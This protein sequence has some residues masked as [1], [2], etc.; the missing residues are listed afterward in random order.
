MARLNPEVSRRL[1]LHSSPKETGSLALN[2]FDDARYEVVFTDSRKV[3]EGRQLWRGMVVNHPDS[4]VLMSFAD[5]ALAGTIVFPGQKAFQIQ[6]TASGSQRISE[7]NGR[8][9]PAC[10]AAR[11]GE[12]CSHIQHVMEP[13][14]A[15]LPKSGGGTN[16]IID[17]LVVYTSGARSGAGG[18]TGMQAMVDVAMAEANVALE[19]S[20]VPA[21]FQLVHCAEIDY[22]DTEDLHEVLDR[23]EED[24]EESPGEDQGPIRGVH[25]L[26]RQYR[27]DLV[28]MVVE[29]VGGPAGM[30]NLMRDVEVE[31]SRKAF[32]VVRR[33]FLNSYFLLAHELAH[34]LGCQH[35]RENSSGP[36]AFTFAH[37]HRFEV[38]GTNYHTVLAYQPGLA[39]PYFSNPEV[40]FLGVPT[41][42]VEGVSNAANNAWTI[43]LAASTVAQFSSLLPTGIPPQVSLVAPVNGAVFPAPAVV[44]LT[45]AASDVD[46]QI[47]KVEFHINGSEWATVHA[48]PF[49]IF[50]SN[51][52]AG[53]FSLRAKAYDT[54]GLEARSAL[55]S[56][57]FTNPPPK[58]D[59][60]AS[61]RQLDGSFQ[62]RLLGASGQG[63]RIEATSDLNEWSLL[64]N[65]TF[66]TEEY[67]FVDFGATNQP[68]RFYRVVPDL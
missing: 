28:C 37:G 63:F 7:V 6:T 31:F 48:P 4:L 27:A 40:T 19:N 22:S 46:G 57:I 61:H 14:G 2:L 59:L 34:N 25:D 10:A 16:E 23:L 26:R 15:N 5:G 50:W 65:D 60:T 67:D 44:E 41:G 51:G 49:R 43:Q 18:V 38:G 9:G 36:G 35:D 42:V 20:L 21:R 55:V 3:G 39:I 32:S 66:S 68:R 17:V 8:S 64:V 53:V 52:V 24:D 54:S 33:P 30:A 29:G 62:L 11:A 47:A 58:F 13:A 45:A 56:V 12:P 1:Q